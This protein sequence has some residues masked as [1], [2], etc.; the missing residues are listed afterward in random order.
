MMLVHILL[1]VIQAFIHALGSAAMA[2]V[3]SFLLLGAAVLGGFMLLFA[4]FSV[5]GI[6]F[7]RK[8]SR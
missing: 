2:L 8:R 7:A 1:G 6:G 5:L 3:S 4:L